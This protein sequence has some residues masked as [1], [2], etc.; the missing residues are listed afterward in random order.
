MA[1]GAIMAAKDLGLRVPE[2]ISVIGIDNHDMSSFFE[3]STIDQQ[4]R[5]QGVASAKRLLELLDDPRLEEH[6][7]VTEDLEWPV[8]LVVRSSTARPAAGSR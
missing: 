5:Q 1:F 6:V 4:V 7:N 8:H 2:D 3:L